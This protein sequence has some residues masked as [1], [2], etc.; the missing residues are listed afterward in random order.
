MARR[1]PIDDPRKP[2]DNIARGREPAE[3]VLRLI[4]K[5]RQTVLTAILALFSGV[6]G[7]CVTQ[8][9]IDKRELVK[10]RVDTV[11]RVASNRYDLRGEEF[12]RALNEVFIVFND[13]AEVMQRLR[14]F[15]EVVTLRRANPEPNE[16]LVALFLS[17]C[18]SARLQCDQ[19]LV[20]HPFNTRPSSMWPDE[21][22]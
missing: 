5:W 17:M 4:L 18:R 6:L 8:W 16:K 9:Q 1:R 7:S 11:K 21:Q 14:E 10:L 12:S 19:S 2:P 3:H 22:Q 15:H 20:L 13:D